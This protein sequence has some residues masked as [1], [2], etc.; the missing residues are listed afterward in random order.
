MNKERDSIDIQRAFRNSGSRVLEV[1]PLMLPLRSQS[2][3]IRFKLA[4]PH[5]NEELFRTEPTCFITSLCPL[6]NQLVHI[7]YL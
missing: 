7:V 2:N 1:S 4:E 6:K 5:M 3:S